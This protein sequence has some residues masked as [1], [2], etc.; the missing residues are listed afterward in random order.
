MITLPNYIPEDIAQQLSVFEK[1]FK[2]FRKEDCQLSLNYRIPESVFEQHKGVFG[3][4]YLFFPKVA[5]DFIYTPAIY[6]LCGQEL[7][8]EFLQG[9]DITFTLNLE[10]VPREM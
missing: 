3:S 9:R 10:A 5:T 6:G 1:Y 2:W 4:L 7:R 8:P